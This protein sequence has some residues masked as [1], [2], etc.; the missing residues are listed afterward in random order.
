MNRE[1][2]CKTCKKV[3]IAEKN[4]RRYCSFICRPSSSKKYW[5]YK[6][7]KREWEKERECIRCKTKFIP[8]NPLHKL[9]TRE[10]AKIY[11]SF[12]YKAQNGSPTGKDKLRFEVFK[13]DN[14]TCQYCGRNVKDDHIKIHCDHIHPKSK[15]GLW[16]IDNLITSCKECNLGK[17]DVLLA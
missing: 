12:E 3:F 2:K 11:H 8:V 9:C 17:N 14:F 6:Y 7:S 10:C 5:T 15:N 16:S 4:A 13:R 1:L